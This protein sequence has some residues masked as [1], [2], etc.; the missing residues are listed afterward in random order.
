MKIVK[1]SCIKAMIFILLTTLFCGVIYTGL[2]TVIAQILF[3]NKANGSIIEA[4]GVT[5][6]SSLIGQY[7]TGNRYMWSRFN[8]PETNF[9][10]IVDSKR[11]E[12]FYPVASNY[13]PA[14]IKYEKIIKQRI[15]KVKSAHPEKKDIPV[16]VDLVTG[17]GSALDPHISYNAAVYQA[18]RIAKIRRTDVDHVQ[19]II[20]KC[21]ENKTFWGIFGNKTVNVLKVNL[22]LDG[23]LS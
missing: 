10:K 21:T 8:E 16:P 1:N 12:T 15:R 3:R 5:Y 20:D 11:K 22:Y 14:G 23:I 4:D 9:I 18:E 13:S 2:V 6:G 17:S 7:F 19:K